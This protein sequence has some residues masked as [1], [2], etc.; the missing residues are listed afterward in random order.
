MTPNEIE[1]LIH[2]HV[3][4]APHPRIDALAVNEATRRMVDNG[5]I[6]Q[7]EDEGYHTTDR[8]RAHISQLCTLPWPVAVWADRDGLT[9]DFQHQ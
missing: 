5:L 1:I 2:Y 4:P 7:R 3:S 9:I 6:E 8:G